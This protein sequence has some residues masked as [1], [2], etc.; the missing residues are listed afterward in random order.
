MLGVIFVQDLNYSSE[1][2]EIP[3]I[4]E[5][6]EIRFITSSYKNQAEIATTPKIK[7]HQNIPDSLSN[8]VLPRSRHS[9]QG[10]HMENNGLHAPSRSEG[11]HGRRDNHKG[12][13]SSKRSLCGTKRTVSA[14]LHFLVSKR[15]KKQG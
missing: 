2:P 10:H 4:P 1:I 11:N 13:P 6:S 7:E 8:Q 9:L 15:E 3:E 5:F 12:K 14:K